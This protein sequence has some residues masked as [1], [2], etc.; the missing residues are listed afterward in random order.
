MRDDV[1]DVPAL[2]TPLATT[3]TGNEY[4][5]VTDHTSEVVKTGHEYQEIRSLATLIRKAGGQVTV[6][7][8]IKG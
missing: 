6:F 1:R 3:D 5:L 4:L 8:A 7:K 2:A